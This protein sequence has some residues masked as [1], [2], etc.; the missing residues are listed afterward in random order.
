MFS[1][2]PLTRYFSNHLNGELQFA[3]TCFVSMPK[4]HGVPFLAGS[5]SD[6]GFVQLRGF[7]FLP[8]FER[9]REGGGWESFCLLVDCLNG[10]SSQN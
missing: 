2:E 9:Q 10:H 3:N 5:R 7:C 4:G 8:L 1:S 6:K